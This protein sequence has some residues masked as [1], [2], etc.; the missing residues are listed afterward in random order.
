MEESLH[1]AL[2]SLSFPARD[3]SPALVALK[4]YARADPA[5]AGRT[6]FSLLQFPMDTPGE[7]I[8]RRLVALHADVYGFS[9]YV[10]NLT[11]V[12]EVLP[13]LHDG[14]P[15]ARV[16]LGGPEVGPLAP[17]LLADHPGIEFVVEGEGEIPFRSLLGCL[18]DGREPSDVPGLHRRGGGGVL[19][20]PPARLSDLAA[21][22][23]LVEDCDYLAYLDAVD[24]PVTAALET[25]RG[26]PFRC[27]FCA[28]GDGFKPRFRPIEAVK[29][30]LARLFAHPRVWRVYITDGDILLDKRRAKALLPYIASINAERKPVVFEMNPELLDA[31]TIGLLA[32]FR[33]DEFALGLQST[34]PDALR[35]M[36]RH[37][38]PARY[39]QRVRELLEAAPGLRVWFSLIVGLPRDTLAGFR[40]SLDFA[41]GMQPHS[42]YIHELL[43]LPGSRFFRDQAS[44]GIRCSPM[45]PHRLL[46]HETMPP[47]DYNRAKWLGF[48]V[49]ALH[50]FER[51]V[52]AL[53]S[54]HAAA[55]AA[56]PSAAVPRPIDVFE[57]FADWLVPRVDLLAGRS[58][59]DVTS[60]EFDGCYAALRADPGM[61]A[62]LEEAVESFSVEMQSGQP[63]DV[64]GAAK[65]VRV[66]SPS[67]ER[68]PPSQS[69][70][71]PQ[72]VADALAA[73]YDTRI[74]PEWEPYRYRGEPLTGGTLY[75]EDIGAIPGVL[76]VA[77]IERYQLRMRLLAGTGDTVLTA[78]RVDEAYERYNQDQLGLGRPAMVRAVAPGIS[79]I[80]V[81]AS[82]LND[83]GAL[84]R[85][86]SQAARGE[87]LRIC[88]Y[89]GTEDAWTLAEVLSELSGRTVS[90]VAPP[91]NVTAL[92]ND[93]AFF[94][95]VVR[96]A[97]GPASTVDTR[98]ARRIGPVVSALREMAGR[99]PRVALKLGAHASAAGNRVFDGAQLAALCTIDVRALV[100]RFLADSVWNGREEICVVEWRDDIRLSPSAQLWIPPSG[101]PVLEGLFAQRLAGTER[102]FAGSTTLPATDPVYEVFAATSLHLAAVFQRLGYVGRCSFDAIVSGDDDLRY[103]ECNGRWGGT[104]I[105]MTFVKRLFGSGVTYKAEDCVDPGLVGKGFPA[106]RE[107][108]EDSLF[109]RRSGEG[110]HI[111]YNVGGIDTKGRYGCIS[112]AGQ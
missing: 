80:Q 5:I 50:Q 33:H 75:V 39:R 100:T 22:P 67:N 2:V 79:P 25:A 99:H 37:F 29:A 95:D 43:C 34:A 9:C 6:R 109:H 65:H 3:L 58:I 60:F 45:P 103:V 40:D 16:V 64:A 88:P 84:S 73:R 54:L 23:S 83:P 13:A 47:A 110:R 62:R 52:Q 91:P 78:I 111:L 19:S 105:P 55:S 7:E 15:R 93:K 74:P 63:T 98:S 82:C 18:L 28:W 101:A 87:L 51:V 44:L 96:S 106:L 90:V 66:S 86:A 69:W 112:L 14:V 104:S 77:G 107:K 71:P 59:T 27:G 4:R 108:Y 97:F 24:A 17:A 10:W 11:A 41:I 70:T 53:L 85:L 31:E 1:V 81:I 32:Q 72:V 21:L 8:V 76:R 57:R 56:R 36:G 46:E 89:M 92:A 48:S 49:G 61:S 38:N 42:L 12:L 26:C 35:A 20:N 94:T 68:V 30:D 102:A